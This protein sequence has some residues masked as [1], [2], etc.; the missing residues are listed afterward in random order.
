MKMVNG[1]WK[2]MVPNSQ[3]DSGNN[4]L[5]ASPAIKTYLNSMSTESPIINSGA[6][7]ASAPIDEGR[8]TTVDASGNIITLTQGS[9][10]A[11][12]PK[13]TSAG[14]PVNPLP[15][16]TSVATDLGL[17]GS[18]ATPSSNSDTIV[19]YIAGGIALIGILALIFKN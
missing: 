16:L 2:N 14:S 9:S 13:I 15:A 1:I 10:G 12:V 5:L 11:L 4:I 19:I 8:I 18:A 3:D 7:P 6:A 17:I